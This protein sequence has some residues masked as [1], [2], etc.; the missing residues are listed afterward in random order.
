MNEF[1]NLGL[2]KFKIEALFLISYLSPTL[3]GFKILN[4]MTK[5]YDRTEN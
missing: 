3:S 1:W 2:F 5:I 4:E